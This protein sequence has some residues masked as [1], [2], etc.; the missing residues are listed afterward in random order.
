[1]TKIGNWMIPGR[2]NIPSPQHTPDLKNPTMDCVKSTTQERGTWKAA[3]HYGL[4]FCNGLR[5]KN[6][7]HALDIQGDTFWGLVFKVYFGGPNTKPRQV[8]GCLGMYIM[9]LLDRQNVEE[10]WHNK[11]G[12]NKQNHC[13]PSFP[14]PLVVSGSDVL[15]KTNMSIR[16]SKSQQG[17]QSQINAMI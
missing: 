2:S 15:F 3:S 5:N 7:F 9:A 6:D 17:V 11:K 13:V 12:E 10:P 14:H 1:M 4:G 8:F 16:R